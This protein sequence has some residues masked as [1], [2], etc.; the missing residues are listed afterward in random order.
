[1]PDISEQSLHVLRGVLSLS[2]RLRSVR[3][4]GSVTLSEL[5]ILAALHRLGPVPARQLAAEERLRPQSLTRIVRKLMR[6][7][8]ITRTANPGDRREKLIALTVKG[9]R[10]LTDDLGARRAWL[11]NAMAAA[12]AGPERAQLRKAAVAMLKLAQSD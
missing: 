7:R 8:L 9:R 5:S 1:M 6:L 2:R 12:L 4:P 10:T 3:P 11:E